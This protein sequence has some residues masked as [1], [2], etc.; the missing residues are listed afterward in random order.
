MTDL[1]INKAI[2]EETG[3]RGV[4]ITGHFVKSV[5][6]WPPGSHSTLTEDREFVRDYANDDNAMREVWSY[7]N[8][9]DR[10]NLEVRVKWINTL[11]GIVSKTCPVNK[12][13]TAIVSDVD[14]MLATTRQHAE[15]VLRMR[16]KWKDQKSVKHHD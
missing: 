7:L 5:K 14:L 8:L 15:A 3:W 11:R 1:E 13:G 16:G 4:D 2:A 10:F 6:G 9:T 12:L